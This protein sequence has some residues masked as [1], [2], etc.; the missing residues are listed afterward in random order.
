MKTGFQAVKLASAAFIV[1]YLMCLNPSLILVDEIVETTIHFLPIYRALPVIV[2][3]LIGMLCLAGGIEGYL[4][5]NSKWYERAV[6]IIAAVLLLDPGF[7]TDA[8]GL[9]ALTLVYLLQK[10][11]VKKEATA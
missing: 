9:G 7:L 4:L 5:T 10:S 11:R 3:A 1:P 6:L 2:S 8:I